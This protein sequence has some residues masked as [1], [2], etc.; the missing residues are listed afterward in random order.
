MNG[1]EN[2]EIYMSCQ[3]GSERPEAAAH[4]KTKAKRMKLF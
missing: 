4:L 1:A 2:F 3:V